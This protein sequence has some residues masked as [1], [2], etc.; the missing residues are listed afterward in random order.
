[1]QVPDNELA[2]KAQLVK[3]AL[4][5]ESA[6]LL[7]LEQRALSAMMMASLSACCAYAGLT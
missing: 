7:G 1:M 5:C 3:S 2:G 6:L 4:I